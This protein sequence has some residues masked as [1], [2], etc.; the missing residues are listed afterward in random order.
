MN[1]EGG[2]L[3]RE[4]EIPSRARSSLFDENV[5]LA[6]C[7]RIESGWA[8]EV[9]K[10]ELAVQVQSARAV[11][12]RLKNRGLIAK[13]FDIHTRKIQGVRHIYIVNHAPTTG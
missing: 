8:M 3:I 11:L 7:K 4:T 10:E 13:T 6:L 12:Q 5:V 1:V 2:K 9:T